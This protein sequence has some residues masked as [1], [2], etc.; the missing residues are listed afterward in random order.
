[1][2]N[3]KI[4]TWILVLALVSAALT[5]CGGSGY[6]KNEAM[7]EAAPMAPGAMADMAEPEEGLYSTSVTGST[8]VSAQQKLITT[9][10]ISAETEDLDPFMAEISGKIAG[11]GGYIEYQDVYN[12]SSRSTYRYRSA[13]MT[14]R[15]PA[16]N[17]AGFVA[18]VKDCSNVISYNESQEDVT[19]TYVSTESRVKA[20]ETQET[21]LLELLEQAENMTELLEI[22]A[23]LSEVRYELERVASSLLV[24]SNQVSYATVHLD[25]EQVKAYTEVE[26][27]T[28]WQRIASGF[29]KNLKN[30]GEDLV[31]FFVWVVTYSPQLVIFAAIVVLVVVII[32]RTS[33]KRREK[34]NPPIQ[35]NEQT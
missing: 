20:L 16:D 18:Q 30:M 29:G 17:L 21:R 27:Q 22:E 7:V 24:L 23:R 10:H 35:E 1:M 5:G 15:I 26:E 4:L 33:R 11:L 19:L 31:N 25:I 12:G 3:R 2:K 14:I 6:A 34:K 9:V 32:R 13:S 28:V 8:E